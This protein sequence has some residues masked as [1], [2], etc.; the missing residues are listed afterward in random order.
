MWQRPQLSGCRASAIEKL[1]RAWQ[2][3]Q[4]PLD[5]SGF[6]RPIPEFGQVAGWS[7]PFSI[8]LM[9]LPWQPGAPGRH[10]L[11]PF[12]DVAEKI[13]ERA[14]KTRAPL[15]WWDLANSFASLS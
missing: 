2:A 8:T 9:M 6:T 11:R 3:E 5:P 4:V 7:F 12:H 15:A 13:I 1:C 10:D 14:G